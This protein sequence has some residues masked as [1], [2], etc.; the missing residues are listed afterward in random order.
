MPAACSRRCY[1]AFDG[2]TKEELLAAGASLTIGS[3]KIAQIARRDY[4]S[5]SSRDVRG[6]GYVVDSLE[7]A[8]WCFDT[9]DRFESAI[10]EAVNLG[11]D[12]D[13]TAAVCGQIAGAFYGIEA[14]PATWLERPVMRPYI[15]T[16]AQLI[17]DK[18][19]SRT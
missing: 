9:A 13:T 5:K 8:L 14:I 1:A 3:P 11:D 18:A 4:R 2:A 16:L 12:A 6:S 19:A 15:E 10:L 7:A 17:H